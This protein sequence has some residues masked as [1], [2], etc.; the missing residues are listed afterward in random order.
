MLIKQMYKKIVTLHYRNFLN[1]SFA[2]QTRCHDFLM[3][4]MDLSDIDISKF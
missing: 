3:L 4:S 2:F 1:Y